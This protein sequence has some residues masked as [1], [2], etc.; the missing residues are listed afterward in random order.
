M[1]FVGSLTS[2]GKMR[3]LAGH[4]ARAA[5]GAVMLLSGASLQAQAAAPAATPPAKARIVVATVSSNYRDG[6]VRLA[7][8]YEKTHP[9]VQVQIQ[10]QPSNGYETWMRTQ[11]ASGIDTAPDIFNVNFA[12]GFYERGMLVDFAQSLSQKNPYTGKAWIETLDPQFV[13]KYKQGGDCPR[14]PVDFV[15]IAFFYNKEI[16]NKLGLTPPHTWEEMLEQAKRIKQAG[17][18]PFAVPGDTDSYWSGPMGWIFRF[19]TDA[20]LRDTLTYC[21]SKPGDWDFVEKNNGNFK[22]DLNDPY[23]DSVVV[24]SQERLLCAVRD[25]VIR[26]DD[27]RFREA[28]Q[29][30]KEFAQYWQPGFNG[31]SYSAAYQLFL[32]RKAAVMINSSSCIS[33]LERDMS[34]MRPSD[35]FE[36]AVYPIPPLKDSKFHIPPFRG[37]GGAGLI[38]GAMKKSPEQTQ[39]TIDFLMFITT[40]Y[41][42]KTLVEEAVKANQPLTG[43]M[44]IPGAQMPPVIEKHFAA[45]RGLGFEK[46]SFRGLLDEQESVWKW[47][48]W[49]QR[50]LDGR[51]SLDQCLAHYQQVID[52]AVPRVMKNMN[53]DMDP[54]TKDVLK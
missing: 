50:Y 19:F 30:I 17:Y 46:V 54:K 2:I 20:Y 22:L 25:H 42:A 47:T 49:A 23:N 35:H 39:R 28:Y 51:I 29:K 12:A 41:A 33:S 18:V 48:V 8:E 11:V 53:F 36:W 9:G 13:E 15:E 44:L 45:F 43:P 5:L 7:K 4:A 14:L 6:L 10:I 37:V 16:F 52:E 3:R 21:A 38:W 34:Q 1:S 24:L 31:T 32:T 26:V 40:P 27:E